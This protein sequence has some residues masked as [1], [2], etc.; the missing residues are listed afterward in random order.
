[1]PQLVSG[2]WR[3]QSM[4]PRLF[5]DTVK[6]KVLKDQMGLPGLITDEAVD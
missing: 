4:V 1:M 3:D 6:V 2:G 5:L